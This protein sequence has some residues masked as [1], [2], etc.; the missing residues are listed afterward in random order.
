MLVQKDASER[1]R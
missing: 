1:H